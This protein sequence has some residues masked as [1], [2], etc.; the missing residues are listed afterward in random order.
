M[1]G[2]LGPYL[3]DLGKKIGSRDI[4][5]W[6]LGF[7]MGTYGPKKNFLSESPHIM[8]MPLVQFVWHFCNFC[9]HA[10]TCF[11]GPHICRHCALGAAWRTIFFVLWV[12]VDI[13]A[14][15]TAHSA[16][17]NIK[18]FVGECCRVNIQSNHLWAFTFNNCLVTM[19]AAELF[20]TVVLSLTSL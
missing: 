2:L 7:P 15:G 9:S 11:L 17:T 16:T 10:G 13:E 12:V 14:L 19:G 4:G 18:L 5:S 1:G 8:L 3:K 20:I 6:D